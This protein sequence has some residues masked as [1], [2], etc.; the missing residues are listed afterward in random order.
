MST[1]SYP[2]DLPISARREKTLAAS[3][4]CSKNFAS[5]FA[6]EPGTRQPVSAQRLRAFGEFP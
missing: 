4:G 5:L 2:A 6:Q 3:A 1:I